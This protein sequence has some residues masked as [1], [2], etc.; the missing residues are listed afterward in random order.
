MVCTQ[1][2]EFPSLIQILNQDCMKS[3]KV[4]E[5]LKFFVEKYYR[6]DVEIKRVEIQCTVNKHL[7][8]SVVVVAYNH[9]KE[10]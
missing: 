5:N 8:K 3:L 10:K 4:G 6:L 2:G 1:I 9:Y 7:T